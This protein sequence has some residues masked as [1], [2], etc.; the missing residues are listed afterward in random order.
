VLSS[1]T[2]YFVNLKGTTVGAQYDQLN[3]S[4]TVNLNGATLNVAV[5]SSF[6]PAAGDTFVIVNNDLADP[7]V[8][9]FA[10]LPEGS[11]VAANAFQFKISYVGGD[12][13]DVV[14]T[15]VASAFSSVQFS[16]SS[17][18]VNEGAGFA[19]ISLT[20][21]GDTSGSA[22][23]DF[24][25][26]D[27]GAEQ[28]TDYTVGAGTV[29][30]AAGETSKTFSVLVVDDVYV[31]SNEVLNLTLSNPTGGAALVSPNVAT[32]TIVDNDSSSPTTNPLDTSSFFVRQ[33]YFDF[34]SRFPDQGGSDFWTSV[35]TQCG[36][37]P[38][39]IRNK[40]IDVSNAFFYE[41][42]FQQTGAYVFRLYRA[43]FG[44]NQPFP[45]PDGSNQTEA[46][47]LPGYAVFARD[48]ARVVGG[49][50]LPTGQRSLTNAF[51]LRSEF[52]LKY[53]A[54][55]DGPTFVD[56]VLGIIRNELGVD[57]TAH[58]RALITLF[59]S[60]GRGAVL[61]RLADDNLQTNPINNRAFI[62]EEYNR[63]FVATQ[64]FGY[65]RRDADIGGFLF[66]LGQVN[67]G[68]SRDVA[69]QHAMV[70]SFITSAEYQQRF[71]PIVTHSN[72]ECG[73]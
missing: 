38:V 11:S 55:Q 41:L 54:S 71:S 35:I 8:G 4:G 18:F 46:K 64:Y 49:A 16:A 5:G 23:V 73:Q 58:R 24:E 53:P 36:S 66:W 48:R 33:H 30:F 26:S 67:S 40:R 29:T 34:L 45:N 63:A 68:P 62:D 52:L 56:A 61:Y 22:S 60:G 59:N 21:T 44:N 57:L 27:I 9:T 47:K 12:G 42:E 32:L 39:C 15:A 13:N 69:K 10:G 70:C 19:T 17:Y 20:R 3:V 14:L 43:A 72:A 50:D 1:A 2:S 25:T 7:I 28:R 37:D 31:E 65:L 6:T 51:V